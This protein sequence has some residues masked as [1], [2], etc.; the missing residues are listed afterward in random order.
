MKTY[1]N[2]RCSRQHQ[3][4]ETFIRCALPTHTWVKGTGSFALISWC[5][6]P[7]ISLWETNAVA[8]VILEDLNATGCRSACR[9]QHEI[10]QLA[11]GSETRAGAAWG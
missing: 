2:H 11:I 10:V 6:R 8:T 9:G 3:K 7:T 5:G 1:K 4:P